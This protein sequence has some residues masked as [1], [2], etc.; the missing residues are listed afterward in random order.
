MGNYVN[1]AKIVDCA[2]WQIRMRLNIVNKGNKGKHED[3]EQWM[4][5][6]FSSRE[7]WESVYGGV[8]DEGWLV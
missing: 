2:K 5:G 1:K 4:V 6:I 3:A 8:Y 7:Q